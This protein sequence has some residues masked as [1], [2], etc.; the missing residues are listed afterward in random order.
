MIVISLYSM[1]GGVGK[2]AAAVNLS[3]LSAKAGF[4]TLLCDLDP[5]GASNYYFRIKASK[6]FGA[7][8]L[9]KGGKNITE[10][11]KATDY[12]NLDLLP[13][14]L[15]HRNIDIELDNFKHSKSR[16]SS[17]LS[18]LDDE[19]DIIFLDCPPGIT[20]LSE[21]IFNS[22]NLIL[23]PVI[24]TTLSVRTFLKLLKF[25]KKN[26]LDRSKIHPFYS[27]VE[28][29]K[30]LHQH[31]IAR[32]SSKIKFLNSQI[33]YRS[34][35]EKMGIY[36]KPLNDYEPYSPAAFAYSSLWNEIM[37]MN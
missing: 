19:Y 4:R 6:G 7:K 13:S 35:V 33:P 23:V 2:T 1:K 16:F 12:D 20:L 5:Q 18:K 31:T 15:A 27:M 24:P 14:K 22:S 29:R 17:I 21:N 34:N 28:I 37:Q 26:K 25:F 3:Y 8:S 11:I 10:N 9:L 30:S 36:R 32:M